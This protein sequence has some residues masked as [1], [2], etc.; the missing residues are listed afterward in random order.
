MKQSPKQ[1]VLRSL[2]LLAAGFA[3]LVVIDQ[4]T[5]WSQTEKLIV[6]IGFA[7]AAALNFIVCTLQ[8]DGAKIVSPGSQSAVA[9]AFRSWTQS[10]EKKA[11]N[12]SNGWGDVLKGVVVSALLIGLLVLGLAKLAKFFEN[13]TRQAIA[14]DPGIVVKNPFVIGHDYQPKPA[15]LRHIW[16]DPGKVYDVFE[17]AKG[18]HWEWYFDHDLEYRIKVTGQEPFTALA[19][20][21]DYKIELPA[22]QAGMLQVRTNHKNNHVEAYR[23]ISRKFN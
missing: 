14:D 22:E 18:Q 9:S 13:N 5:T 23:L 10:P 17:L 7:A 19:H 12:K 1:I 20:R 2:I 6:P 11:V 4:T 8:K 15:L 3:A 16:M 21:P